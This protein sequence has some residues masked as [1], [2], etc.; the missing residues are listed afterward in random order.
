MKLKI[1]A[2]A[3]EIIDK[4]TILEIKAGKIKNSSKIL[5]VI[6]ELREL[7]PAQKKILSNNSRLKKLKKDLFKVNS[8]LWEIENSIR[9]LESKKDFGTKFVKLARSVYINNDKRSGLKN[10]INLIAGSVI[11]EVKEY[12]SYS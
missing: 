9:K 7:S 1:S 5:S 2:S 6:R 11:S 4:V 10:K 8:K 12:S 3:G